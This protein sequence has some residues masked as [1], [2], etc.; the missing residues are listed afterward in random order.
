MNY[1]PKTNLVI[2]TINE[3]IKGFNFKFINKFIENMTSF[4]NI[5]IY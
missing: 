4:K 2:T 1:C 5:H 3:V